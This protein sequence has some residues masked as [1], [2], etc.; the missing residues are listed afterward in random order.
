MRGITI[1]ST[2]SYL[3]K[4]CIPNEAFMKYVDTSDEWIRTRTGIKTRH[5]ANGEPTWYM[6]AQAARMALERSGVAAEKVD[7]ILV[8]CCT[9]DYMTPSVACMIQRDLG[10]VN[11]ICIDLNCACSGCAHGLDMA[12]RYLATDDDIQNV[13]MVS[14]ER[15]SQMVDFSDRSVCVLLGDGAGAC[16]VRRKEDAL[17]AFTG[18][19]DGA[20][21][22]A[23]NVKYPRHESPF[24]DPAE[25]GEYFEFPNVREKFLFMDGREVY[26]FSTRVF[27]EMMKTCCE[28][29]GL[30][31]SDLDHVIPHQANYRIVDTALKSLPG[32][33]RGKVFLNLDRNGNTGSASV[34]IALDEMNTKGMLKR[35]E[36]IALMGFGG[37]L[38]YAGIVLEW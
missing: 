3:P 34:L 27:P 29:L 35:G 10:A 26:R 5:I 7:L 19:A 4:D 36:K 30:Q 33:D 13:L 17:Y 21:G 24:G 9:P 6:G 15:L 12:R 8:S 25:R 14:T 20:S 38:T 31:L 22:G 32:L 16:L 1:V 23:L 18:G 2:G 28:K 11:A 37:G